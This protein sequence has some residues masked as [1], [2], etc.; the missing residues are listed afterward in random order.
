MSDKRQGS[1]IISSLL[2]SRP[3]HRSHPGARPRPLPPSPPPAASPPAARPHPQP[4][5]SSAGPFLVCHAGQAPTRH[6]TSDHR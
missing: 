6:E 3:I 1:S 4:A 5:R 2:G